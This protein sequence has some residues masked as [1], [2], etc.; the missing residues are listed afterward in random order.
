MP[1]ALD[2]L[3]E[4]FQEEGETG[5]PQSAKDL[6]DYVEECEWYVHQR[7][8][9]KVRVRDERLKRQ[10]GGD[11]AVDVEFLL[12]PDATAV[13][14]GPMGNFARTITT[15]STG[16]SVSSHSLSRT[17]G[18]ALARGREYGHGSGA[19][20]VIRNQTLTFIKLAIISWKSSSPSSWIKAKERV[21]QFLEHVPAK[22]YEQIES[23]ASQVCRIIM[24]ECAGKCAA[25]E[26]TASQSGEPRLNDPAADAAVGRGNLQRVPKAWKTHSFILTLR[27]MER[28]QVKISLW[29][30]SRDYKKQHRRRVAR[31]RQTKQGPNSA[32]AQVNAV[33]ASGQR[34]VSNLVQEASVR[35]AEA[36]NLASTLEE[37]EELSP[38]EQAAAVAAEELRKAELEVADQA[39]LDSLYEP[40][41]WRC[42]RCLGILL[43]TTLKCQNFIR[44]RG[45]GSRIGSSMFRRCNGSQTETWEATYTRRT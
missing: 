30:V 42:S 4:T 33:L 37:H 38:D 27:K 41:S 35:A 17:M 1:A 32:T 11:N 43:Q 9:Q 8:Q 26:A 36:E 10:V 25:A 7:D 22:Q 3:A 6:A 31:L 23:W 34:G 21:E 12:G 16:H 29:S 14:Q 45:S 28:E 18:Q 20:M 24:L 2:Q 40:G 5:R 39:T 19:D 13:N 15:G 44:R